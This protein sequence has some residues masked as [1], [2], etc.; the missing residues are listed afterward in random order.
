LCC[1]VIGF[2][3]CIGVIGIVAVGYGVVSVFG[4]SKQVKEC[5]EEKK[6]GF[7]LH[8][9]HSKCSLSLYFF[10]YLFFFN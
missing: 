1:I 7:L 3:V 9:V 4:E 10:I 6:N 5:K 8:L 2:G